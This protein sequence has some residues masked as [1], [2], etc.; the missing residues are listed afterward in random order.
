MKKSKRNF[1]VLIFFSF[2][3]VSIVSIIFP[4]VIPFRMFELWNTSGKMSDWLIASW[5]IF[6][7]AIGLNVLV[8]L[9]TRNRKEHNR[10]AEKIFVGG[11][12]LSLIA[13]VTEEIGFR[14]LIFLNSILI[15]KI[16][17]FLF[18]GFLGLPLAEPVYKY[19]SA[20]IAN[21]L[22]MGSMEHI[23]FHRAG[24]SVGAGLMASNSFFSDGHKYLGWLGQVNSWFIGMFMFLILFEYGLLAWITIHFLYDLSIFCVRY[25]DIAIE[26]AIG[27]A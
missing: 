19:F 5:P 13:G 23:L 10:N 20:P 22:T 27:W 6:A 11:A 8:S 3:G 7:W 1:I 15:I 2:I 25:V 16:M 9:T 12:V 21:F 14:W 17:N 24:W 18:F 26:R 4:G